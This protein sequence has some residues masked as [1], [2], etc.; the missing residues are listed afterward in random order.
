MIFDT[1]CRMQN[2]P[3]KEERQALATT[4]PFQGFNS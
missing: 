4:P 3:D 2:N 1:Q